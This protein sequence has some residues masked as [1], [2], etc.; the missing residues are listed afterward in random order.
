MLKQKLLN[1][2]LQA[3]FPVLVAAPPPGEHDPEDE[4]DDSGD[5]SDSDNP[6]HCAAQVVICVDNHCT[7]PLCNN[8]VKA[9]VDSMRIKLDVS[10]LFYFQI[11]D[12][13]A[14]HMPPEKLFQQLVSQPDVSETVKDVI[15]FSDSFF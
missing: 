2:I 14:L 5:G 3:I 15:C 11:I 10:F 9:L 12:T 1:P 8:V 7:L 6:K 4:E 13:M